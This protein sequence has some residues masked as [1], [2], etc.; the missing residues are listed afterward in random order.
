MYATVIV[1][2]LRR[3]DKQIQL[4]INSVSFPACYLSPQHL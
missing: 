4:N 1:G 3:F 2:I